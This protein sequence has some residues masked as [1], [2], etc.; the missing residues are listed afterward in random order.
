MQTS[1]PKGHGA[2]IL[3]VDDDALIALNMVDVLIELGHTAL[4]AFS[5]SQALALMQA[6]ID[7][8]ALITDYAMPGMNGIELASAA[9]RL[10]PGLPILLAT[11]YDEVPDAA[12]HDFVQLRKPFHEAELTGCLAQVLAPTTEI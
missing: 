2:T 10:R 12:G 7:I 8:S 3:V 5:G 1:P 4:G 9:R 11:G 6:E